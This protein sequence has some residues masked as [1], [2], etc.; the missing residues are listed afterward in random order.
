MA[1]LCFLSICFY[2][3]WNY[4]IIKALPETEGISIK[5]REQWG[6]LSG[7]IGI[8]LN[9]ALFIFKYIYAGQS[10]SIALRADALNNLMDILSSTVIVVGFTVASRRADREHPYGH[11]RMEH[12][13]GLVIAIII[14]YTGFSLARNSVERI[15]SPTPLESSSA[16]YLMLGAGILAKALVTVFNVL[17]GKKINSDTLL[18]NAKDSGSDVLAT[19]AVLFSLLAFDFWG[20]KLDGYAGLVVS[21]MIIFAGYESFKETVSTI[22]GEALDDSKIAEIGHFVMG[23]DKILSVHDIALHSYG[24]RQNLLTMHVE[25]DGKLSLSQVHVIIDRLERKIKEQF[26]YK[27]LIHVDP[28]IDCRTSAQHSLHNIVERALNSTCQRLRFTDF[29]CDEEGKRLSFDIYA[30]YEL[31]MSGKEI[32]MRVETF[33]RTEWKEE[34]KISS[35]VNR[36]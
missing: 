29:I 8:A 36:Y 20:L 1:L 21:L 4:C 2:S 27:C 7:V 35:A 31:N 16:L 13:S 6:L 3:P 34:I 28:A 23:N 5:T 33:I 9:I 11:G 12:I 22:M 19:T 15:L 10:G 24:V 32:R 26:G 14:L 17:L 18:I 30:P 25:M